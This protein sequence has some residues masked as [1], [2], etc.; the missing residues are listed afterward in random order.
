MDPQIVVG[1][2]VTAGGFPL[3]V[4][5]F[6][7]NTAGTTTLIPVLASF[8][9][10]HK[11]DDIVVVADAGMLSAGNLNALEDASFSF[12][13]GS[14]ISKAPYD[15]VEHFTLGTA[16]HDGETLESKRMMGVGANARERRVVYQYSTKR[17][18][19]DNHTR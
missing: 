6:T 19:R 9:D 13:V 11:V 3:E 16:L 18:R 7:G 2:L 17:D 15:L 12:I 4:H 14:R 10:R 1:L 8:Q 5:A